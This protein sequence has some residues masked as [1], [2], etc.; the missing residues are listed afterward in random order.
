[1]RTLL[2]MCALGAGAALSA[3]EA[4]PAV[5]EVTVTPVEAARH[6][7]I[8]YKLTG[9]PAIVT[10]AVFTNGVH[11]GGA[12]VRAVVGD[13]NALVQPDDERTKRIVWFPDTAFPATTLAAEAVS[14]ELTL[15]RPDTPPDYAAVRIAADD[16]ARHVAYYA[17]EASLPGGIGDARWRTD[18]LLLR[19]IPRS[20][21]PWRMGAPSGEFPLRAKSEVPHL[22]KLTV[23]YYM[24]VFPVTQGQYAAVAGENPSPAAQQAPSDAACRPATNV[25][26]HGQL[27]HTPQADRFRW[28]EDGHTFTTAV[29]MGKL[30][31]RTGV[32]FDL[33]TD[34]QWEYACRAGEQAAMPN[35][36]P[37]GDASASD[38]A[39]YDKDGL[40][41]D[42]IL[43]AP[44]GT[45]RPNAWGLY[46]MLGNVAEWCL[47]WWSDADSGYPAN[48]VNH[49]AA[50]GVCVDPVGPASTEARTWRVLR[51]LGFSVKEEGKARY[52]R[53]AYRLENRTGDTQRPWIG[54]RVACPCPLPATFD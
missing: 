39:W 34:A 35:G 40:G 49:D 38:I 19:R 33:P 37:A 32:A 46:D 7:S 4:E 8:S 50:T 31:A 48:D 13:V 51:G 6:F 27:R 15:W 36:R 5:S 2:A 25:K 21:R 53:S 30:G 54:F 52:L 26:L 17:D 20:D 28:P 11:A 43:P 1:M 14:V 44:V 42:N 12:A 16:D 9:G 22:V 10:M 45:L 3:A 18:Y 24:G 29:F 41:E 47:D 23:D